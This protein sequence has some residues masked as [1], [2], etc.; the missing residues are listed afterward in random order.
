M[1]TEDFV[2]FGAVTVLVDVPAIGGATTGFSPLLLTGTIVAKTE[3]PRK[4]DGPQL[5]DVEGKITER[6][7]FLILRV[8]AATLPLGF[9]LSSAQLEASEIAINLDYVVLILPVAAA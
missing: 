9:P 3:I 6:E 5:I 4:H 2:K 7:T 1:R 8:T